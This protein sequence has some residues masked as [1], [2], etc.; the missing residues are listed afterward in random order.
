[1]QY[2][3]YLIGDDGHFI[4]AVDFDCADDNAARAAAEALA[5]SHMVE[6]WQGERRIAQFGPKPDRT[7]SDAVSH[8][9][10]SG[11]LIP[12]HEK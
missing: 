11:R 5:D 7:S 12:K 9:V 2:R 3:A 6:L 4:R 10:I 8:E 1:M